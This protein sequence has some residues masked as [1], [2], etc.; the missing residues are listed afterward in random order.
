MIVA[1][2]VVAMTGMVVALVIVVVAD[3]GGG[4]RVRVQW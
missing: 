2:T 4:G 3:G 1:V